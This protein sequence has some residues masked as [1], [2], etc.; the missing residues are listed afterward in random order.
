MSSENDPKFV[1][2]R[3]FLRTAAAGIAGITLA[4]CGSGGGGSAQPAG[5]T[6]GTTGGQAGGAAGA[7]GAAFK[8]STWGNPGEIQ[9]FKE[10][11][12][13]YNKRTGAKVELV[14]IPNDGYPQKILTQLSG[15]TAPD[16]FYAGAEH[17][18]QFIK[19]N[20]IV[21]LNEKL[22]G[23]ASKSKPADFYEGLWGAAKTADG[24]IYGATVDCNPM[25]IWCNKQVLQEAG[26]TTMPADLQQ[27]GKWTW[28]AFQDM[29][30]QVVAKGKRGFIVENWYGPLW[31]W[32]TT[33]GG[34]VWDGE[35]FVGDQDAKTKEAFKFV[36]QNL[37]DKTFT[38]SGS[39]P[40]GQG[41]DAMFLSGQAAF[42]AAGRWLL[43]TFK[44]AAN[45]Q[46]DIVT[47]PTNTGKKI[48]P[49]NVP[50]AYIVMNAKASNPE[51]AFA[52]LTDFVSKDGQIFRLKGGGNAVPSIK[53]ADEVVS[54]GN[55]PPNWQAL[56]DAREV[57]YALWSAQASTA[58]LDSEIN[59]TL[60]EVWLKG[61][62]IDAT[63]T[64][65]AEIV[66]QKKGG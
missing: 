7:A 47:W 59:K 12:D 43:P 37:Q 10:F 1:S 17:I 14:P 65:I 44:K 51:G 55:L 61:G 18:G 62:D 11:T 52:F 32:P 26:V 16:V 34:K 20:L 33:N 57:G 45:L 38:Y 30:K 58:G 60:D 64:K 54:E 35:K 13:D 46:Y 50:T 24:K 22:N 48:E 41:M 4:A 36:Q 28:Q 21:D 3:R 39:L 31:S 40:K 49:A 29:C 15:G 19:S 25:V 2:R 23:P 63:F 9:R 42:V 53:G 56:I 6:G 8:W 5:Q 66:K 27:D